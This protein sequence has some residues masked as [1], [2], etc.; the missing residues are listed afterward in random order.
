MIAFYATATARGTT[1]VVPPHKTAR[2]SRRRPR[3]SARDRTIK[4]MTKIGRRRWK[5]ASGDHREARVEHACFR[6]TSISGSR[7][8]ARSPG[9]RATEAV[10]ACNILNRVTELGLPESYRLGR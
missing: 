6:D 7:L 9:D 10:L 3:S 2:V 4:K 8:R 5:Q 1:V